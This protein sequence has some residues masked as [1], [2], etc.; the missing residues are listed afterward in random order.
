MKPD[1]KR[2]GALCLTLTMLLAG[3]L[4]VNATQSTDE[5]LWIVSPQGPHTNIEEALAKASP[6]DTIIVRGGVYPGPLLVD[7]SV[8]LVGEEWP[9][10]DGGG[11]GVVVALNAPA[12]QFRGFDVRGSGSEPDRDH[13]GI[14]LQAADIV[15]EDNRLSDVLFGIFVA[16]ANGAVVRGNDITSKAEYDIA[17]KGDAIRVWYSHNVTVENNHIYSARDVVAW[18][19]NDLVFRKNR[20]VDGRYGVHL[21][22]CDRANITQNSLQDNS[23]GIYIMYSRQVLLSENDIRRQRGPSGYGLGF[24]DADYVDVKGNLLID[25]QAGVFLDGTPYLPDSYARFEDNILAF[26]DIG[27][28]LFSFVKGVEFQ[29]NTFWENV[30]QVALQGSGKAG[31]NLWRNNFWSDYT[32]FDIDGDNIGDVPYQAERFFEGL[33]DQNPALRALLFS[34]AVQGLEL[35]ASAFPVIKPQ[36][37]LEDP[38]PSLSPATIPLTALPSKKGAPSLALVG[39]GMLAG[40]A[41]L[42]AM[43]TQRERTKLM[44]PKQQLDALQYA[45]EKD[46][47]AGRPLVLVSRVS[48]FYAKTRVLN[49]VS[50]TVQP[51]ETVALWGA[52]GAGKTTLIKALLGLVDYQ[53]TITIA[54]QDVKQNGKQAR[55][56]IG[57]VP[58]EAVF[59]DMTV[60]ATVVFYAGIRKVSPQRVPAIMERLGLTSHQHKPVSALSGGLKQRLALAVALLSDPPLL[61]LDEPTANLDASARKEYLALLTTLRNEGKTIIFAS[62]RIEEVES[63]ADRVLI[64]ESGQVVNELKPGSV[65]LH[66]TPQVAITLWIPENQQKLALASLSNRGWQ[67]HLNGRGTL[68]VKVGTEEKLLA[69]EHLLDSGITIK[70]FEM[71]GIDSSWN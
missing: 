8:R 61:L 9:V 39:M 24:K 21:M 30:E 6:G 28:L 1:L 38:A 16:Q 3:R 71:E 13:A 53:G 50:L 41:L 35:A 12:T 64:L 44:K 27:I 59:Y 67:V 46:I 45:S 34:P 22:Y 31:A 19:S 4:Q 58:Q 36:P 47:S 23:V 7:K 51:G 49:N 69:L 20:I 11:K 32:G 43:A 62:H 55:E 66:L 42:I 25:N 14:A 26:N 10:I 2:L 63:L 52:N 15:V 56:Q 29:G 40:G 37:K 54:D 57:Y 65:R 70:D 48:K 17:R 18:Y 5:V 68:V 60:Q 33:T